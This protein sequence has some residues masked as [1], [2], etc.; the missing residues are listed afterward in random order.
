MSEQEWAE[1]PKMQIADEVRRLRS[2]LSS[3][4][5]ELAAVKAERDEAV[6]HWEAEAEKNEKLGNFFHRMEAAEAKLSALTKVE[7][8][9]VAEALKFYTEGHRCDAYDD[10]AAAQH[11]GLVLA[12][13]LRRSESARREI[14]EAAAKMA[15]EL[16]AAMLELDCQWGTFYPTV[17]RRR[18]EAGKA[19]MRIKAVFALPAVKS[20]L[21]RRK[22]ER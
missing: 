16:Q 5:E 21:E 19:Y 4:R 12:N 20:L 3:A 9:E 7:D 2:A 17:K 11:F 14:E 13:A 8:A 15:E 10:P 18:E 1:V 22:G 6:Q